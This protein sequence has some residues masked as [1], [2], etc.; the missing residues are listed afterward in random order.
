M[1]ELLC[2][3]QCEAFAQT[4]FNIIFF[5]FYDVTFQHFILSILSILQFKSILGFNACVNVIFGSINENENAQ[6]MSR[7]AS[8]SIAYVN[9]ANLTSSHRE[10]VSCRSIRINRQFYMLFTDPIL[11]LFLSPS[12]THFFLSMCSYTIRTMLL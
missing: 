6:R 4:I 2:A 12:L 11:F 9:R 8:K 5:F 10:K 7:M 3:S 1:L